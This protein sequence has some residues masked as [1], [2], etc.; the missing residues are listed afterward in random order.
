MQQDSMGGVRQSVSNSEQ[1]AMVG[2]HETVAFGYDCR[3]A[4]G[5]NDGTR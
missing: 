1:P 3:S 2:R 5:R 4:A